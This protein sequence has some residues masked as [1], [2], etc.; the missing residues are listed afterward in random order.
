MCL[1]RIDLEPKVEPQLTEANNVFSLCFLFLFVQWIWIC[2]KCRYL[3][4]MEMLNISIL[5]CGNIKVTHQ[6]GAEVYFRPQSSWEAFAPL[7]PGSYAYALCLLR[8]GN[9]LRK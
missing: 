5:R 8:Q 1:R 4:L 6:N 3:R 2:L 7:P 9:K